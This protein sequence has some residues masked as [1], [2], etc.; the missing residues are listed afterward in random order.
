MR[1]LGR[2]GLM[3]MLVAGCVQAKVAEDVVTTFGGTQGDNSANNL[4]V[5]FI[6]LILLLVVV[7][8]IAGGIWHRWHYHGSKR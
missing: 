3:L 4:A 6:L 1:F 2:L 5:W 8:A 7:A